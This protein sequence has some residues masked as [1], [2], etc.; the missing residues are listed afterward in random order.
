M[1]PRSMK[2]PYSVRFLTVPTTIAPSERCSSVT[3]LR[4]LISS[5][6]ASLRDTTTLPRRRLSLMILTGM[7]WPISESRLCTGRGSACE[8]GMNDLTPT[9]TASPDCHVHL[10]RAAPLL[11]HGRLPLARVFGLPEG[12][13]HVVR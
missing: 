3:L 12:V 9:S 10:E 11:L 1:P 7:S 5:S 8:P 2:A 13:R 6:S 4:E